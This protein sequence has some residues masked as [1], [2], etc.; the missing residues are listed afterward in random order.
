MYIPRELA[1]YLLSGKKATKAKPSGTVVP[2]GTPPRIMLTLA[3]TLQPPSLQ[4][5]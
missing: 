3:L 2:H 4:Q 1:F 5:G